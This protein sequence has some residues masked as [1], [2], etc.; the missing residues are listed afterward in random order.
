MGGIEEMAKMLKD[1]ENEEYLG[2]QVG[3][4]ISLPPDIKVSLNTKVLLNKKKLVVA[5]H[6]LPY[7][8]AFS[9]ESEGNIITKTEP[10]ETYD[11]ATIVESQNQSGNLSFTDQFLKVGDEVILI[12]TTDKQKYF[13][14]DKAVRF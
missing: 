1:R 5:A 4:V 8:R 11:P 3:T 13:L 2:P 7:T 9:A 12:P 10:P 6:L 14:I